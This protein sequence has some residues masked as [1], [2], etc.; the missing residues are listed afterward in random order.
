M[1]ADPLPIATAR[2]TLRRLC[3]DDLRDFQAYRTD[4]AVARYQGWAPMS[5][6]QALAF[7]ARMRRVPLF[8]P[9][10]WSQ[11]GIVWQEANEPGPL[12][13]DIGVG[14][15]GDDVTCAQIGFS[16]HVHWQG[17]GLAAEAVEAA[18]ALL[19]EHAGARRIEGITDARNAASIRLLERLGFVRACT[20]DAMFRGEPCREHHYLRERALRSVRSAA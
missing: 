16:L 3:T 15:D 10:Q 19:F 7:L 12:I 17:R 20:E 13:G 14:I 5:G 8:V 9:G 4:P 6:A 1:L 18:C 11:I 2:T